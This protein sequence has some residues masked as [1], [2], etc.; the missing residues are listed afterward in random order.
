[1]SSSEPLLS[2][3]N[4]HEVSEWTGLLLFFP[5][6]GTIYSWFLCV[7]NCMLLSLKYFLLS[8][9]FV[10][11]VEFCCRRQYD[12]CTWVKITVIIALIGLSARF[13]TASVLNIEF[14]PD[15]CTNYH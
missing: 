12:I 13:V 7:Q 4:K 15:V 6:L 9:L 14:S 10:G 11:V 2:I 1:M 8:T 5:A 3:R